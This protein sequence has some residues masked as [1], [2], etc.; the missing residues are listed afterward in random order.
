ML[1]LWLASTVHGSCIACD[2]YLEGLDGYAD[3]HVYVD[4]VDLYRSWSIRMFNMKC[5]YIIIHVVRVACLPSSL[6]DQLVSYM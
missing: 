2:I 1:E 3:L 4:E 5:M 6:Y